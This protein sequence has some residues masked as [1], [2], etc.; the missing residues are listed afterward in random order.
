MSKLKTTIACALMAMAMILASCAP[1]S[2]EDYLNQFSQ[3]IEEVKTN[4]ESYSDSDWEKAEKKFEKFSGEWYEK[5]DN[6]LST[7]EK[8]K[9]ATLCTQWLYYKNFDGVKESLDDAIDAVKDFTK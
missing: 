7:S 6:E 8:I 9:A 5:F 2:K 3:F 1:S 4:H